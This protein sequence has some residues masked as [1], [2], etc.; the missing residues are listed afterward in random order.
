MDVNYLLIGVIAFFAIS[1]IH[2]YR[3]GF[4][5]IMITLA[6][7]ILSVFI[8]T[9]ISP[10]ISDYLTN[11]TFVY[12]SVKEKVINLVEEN[13]SKLDNTI[14]E[15]QIKTIQS[16]DLPDLIKK[17]LIEHNTKE[18]Y[19]TLMVTLFEDYIASYLSKL[20]INAGT[21]AGLF[22]IL[23]AA[24]WI[25]TLSAKIIA[26][27]PII[28]GIN[29]LLGLGAGFISAL[30]IVW[31]GFF[32]VF[33]FVGDELGNTIMLQIEDSRFLTLLFETNFLYKFIVV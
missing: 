13:N 6:G 14:P 3:K 9:V 7:I 10:Y 28:K 19:Q 1:V 11:N 25:C 33:L 23:T 21:F 5:R 20:I 8:V 18:V 27:I 26:K 32:L 31:I 22:I 24:L 15:N 12:D 30:I 4:L 17:S 2:G 16:Y 29:R